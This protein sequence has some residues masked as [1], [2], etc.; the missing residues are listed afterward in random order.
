MVTP[1]ALFKVSID[2]V[3]IKSLSSVFRELGQTQEI[4]VLYSTLRLINLKPMVTN[5]ENVLD[6]QTFV[7]LCP[8][9]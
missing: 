9:T 2:L 4:K 3:K 6:R 7:P 1:S 8:N 5:L